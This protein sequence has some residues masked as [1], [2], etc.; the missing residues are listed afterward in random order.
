M[1]ELSRD[2]IRENSATIRIFGSAEEINKK[3]KKG[4]FSFT[5][6][7]NPGVNVL[8]IIAEYQ[9]QPARDLAQFSILY[10]P[11]EDI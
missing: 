3:V 1:G 2:Q 4:N 6:K 8:N 11:G 7:I 5:Y 9:G 10:I